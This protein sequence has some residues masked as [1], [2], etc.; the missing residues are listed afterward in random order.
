ME[1]L[2][3]ILLVLAMLAVTEVIA[4]C[5]VSYNELKKYQDEAMREAKDTLEGE[6]LF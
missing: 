5:F 1:A 4:F 3:T 2:Y 6:K